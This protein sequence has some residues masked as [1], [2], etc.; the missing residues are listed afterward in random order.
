[1]I[2]GITA[3]ICS[4]M[5]FFMLHDAEGPNLLI[6]AGL[7]MAL[8]LLSYSA[9]VFIPSGMKGFKRTTVAICIQVLLAIGLYF[10]MR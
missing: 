5:L 2:L 3:T 4:R 10:C 9:Y 6:V 7:A 1:V 8:F